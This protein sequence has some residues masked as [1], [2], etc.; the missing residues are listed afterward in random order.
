MSEESTAQG[1]P[2]Q[3]VSDTGWAN[4]FAEFQ[5]A[6]ESST[7][8][9]QIGE[10]EFFS[11]EDERHIRNEVERMLYE[12]KLPNAGDRERDCLY[13]LRGSD[14]KVTRL[15]RLVNTRGEESEG[16]EVGNAVVLPPEMYASA[17]IFREWCS[18][19]GNFDFGVG[20]G[21]GNLELQ[22]LHAD[23]S[24]DAAYRV[25]RLIQCSGWYELRKNENAKTSL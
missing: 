11:D 4:V 9:A 10:L 19:Q 25:V 13:L 15:V 18:S 6:L 24:N 2:P 12:P 3:S 14:G 20:E 8:P 22:K 16:K 1:W 7:S 23:I 21:A 5:N 17:E